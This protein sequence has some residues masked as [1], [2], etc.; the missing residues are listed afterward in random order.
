MVQNLFKII[1][2]YKK[3]DSTKNLILTP[4]FPFFDLAQS[5]S[6]SDS[7][8]FFF[9]GGNL[10]VLMGLDFLGEYSSSE[11]PSLCSLPDSS[12]DPFLA[13]LVTGFF[14][15]DDRFFFLS[16]SESS[17]VNNV[18]LSKNIYYNLFIS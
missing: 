10:R 16:L 9:L 15:E 12:S 13:F 2:K 17:F 5:S 14:P 3:K 4:F 7:D 8:P 11:S 6:E 1:M 18:R